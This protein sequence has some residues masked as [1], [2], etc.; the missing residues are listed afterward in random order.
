[1]KQLI[2]LLAAYN[3]YAAN[4][5]ELLRENAIQILGCSRTADELNDNLIK[6][7]RLNPGLSL[8]IKNK[9]ID[10]ILSYISHK[11]KDNFSD[12]VYDIQNKGE[13][14]YKYIEPIIFISKNLKLNVLNRLL[15]SSDIDININ[16]DEL[17]NK[18]NIGDLVRRVIDTIEPEAKASLDNQLKGLLQMGLVNFKDKDGHTALMK[19][20]ML[21]L[22]LNDSELTILCIDMISLLIKFGA[23]V[24]I[25]DNEGRTSLMLTPLYTNKDLKSK[26]TYI[27]QLLIDNGADVNIGDNQGNTAL[28]VASA[29]GC[30]DI[31]KLLIT[32]G[33]NINA[34]NNDGH[35]ALIAASTYR[36]KDLESG[37]KKVVKLLID[38]GVDID[39]QD[40]KGNTAIILAS[41]KGYLGIVKLLIPNPNIGFRGANLKIKNN[42]GYMAFMKAFKNGHIDIVNLLNDVNISI[43]ED[44]FVDFNEVKEFLNGDIHNVELLFDFNNDSDFMNICRSTL[45]GIV[46]RNGST[47]MLKSL[48]DDGFN[49][50]ARDIYGSTAIIGASVAR[51]KDIVQLLIDNDVDI[52]ATYKGYSAL[53][54]AS[55]NGDIDIV[56]LLITADADVD[57]KSK[58][59]K[60]ALTLASNKGHMDV[61]RLLRQK[62][63]C[64][65]Q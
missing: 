5:I 13:L 20:L 54:F 26:H 56:K 65:I 53:M 7:S 62:D 61:V 23:N 58:S 4:Y 63:N 41:S 51:N 39:K 29:V 15:I 46:S 21:E 49:I 24:N 40:N 43:Q 57:I 19:T 32:A 50:N 47:D 18:Y 37:C 10:I 17:Y 42:N 11:F 36:Y 25:Q 64:I 28:L 3:I 48:I 38:N 22:F 60:N 16:H 30:I 45:F 9:S 1:M 8:I 33:A 34:Q 55:I 14:Y 6:I 27:A 52:N 2:I 31:V 35:T 12:F 44:P 59:G